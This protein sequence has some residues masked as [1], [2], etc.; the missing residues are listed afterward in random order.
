[1]HE[2]KLKFNS[3]TTTT[4]KF[5]GRFRMGGF[6]GLQLQGAFYFSKLHGRIKTT[7]FCAAINKIFSKMACPFF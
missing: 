5:R 3:L 2:S 1:M 6:R 7:P 4:Q